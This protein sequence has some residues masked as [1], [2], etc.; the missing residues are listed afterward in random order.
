MRFIPQSTDFGMIR[1]CGIPMPTLL[2]R[3]KSPGKF[4]WQLTARRITPHG[5]AEAFVGSDDVG[6]SR[7]GDTVVF[8]HAG[9]STNLDPVAFAR[10]RVFLGRV[11]RM[12]IREGYG[13]ELLDPLSPAM[14]MPALAASA[15]LGNLSPFD[16]LLHPRVGPRSIISALKI[17]HPSLTALLAI[18]QDMKEL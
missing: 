17:G 9:H 1:F 14:N 15:G 7:A 3:L 2:L 11:A 18:A 4:F 8:L 13:A 6:S 10:A 16:L 12:V 5:R